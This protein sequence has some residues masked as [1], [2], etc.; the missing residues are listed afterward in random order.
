MV[1]SCLSASRVSFPNGD[2]EALKVG[3]TAKQ[4][5]TKP[6]LEIAF[7]VDS[8]V[9]RGKNRLTFKWPEEHSLDVL[10]RQPELPSSG[11]KRKLSRSR[12]QIHKKLPAKRAPITH[13]KCLT[14]SEHKNRELSEGQ[15]ERSASAACHH[16]LTALIPMKTT[17]RS[18]IINQGKPSASLSR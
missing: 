6:D 7:M 8:H 9:Y 1:I 10:N 12:T 14:H 3:S 17:Q 11:L 13:T 5:S 16:E 4:S 18:T 2:A 15:T